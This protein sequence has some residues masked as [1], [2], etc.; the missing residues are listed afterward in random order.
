[1][2]TK[3]TFGAGCF[4][5]V[6]EKFR[7]AKKVSQTKVGY[8]GG[9]TKYP[10]YEEVCTGTTG[11]IEVVEV[12]FDTTRVRY[13]ELLELFWKIHNPTQLDRQ[14]NDV[15]EQ[16]KS[17]IFYHS[18]EQKKK[19]FLSKE[20]LE[21]SKKYNAPIVTEIRKAT[22]FFEAEEYHQKYLLK[23]ARKVCGTL[24]CGKK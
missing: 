17:I 6:E 10:T 24:N 7:V 13:E 1:M 3:A 11:H 5:G 20:R 23:H 4:W 9:K 16:Y 22:E 12:S 8:M 14:G 15:G 18:E 21:R 2:I 19:A